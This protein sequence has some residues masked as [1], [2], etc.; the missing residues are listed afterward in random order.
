MTGSIGIDASAKINLHLR[1]L[2]RNADG[3]HGIESL[4]QTV[5]LSDRI[6]VRS[7]KNT[8]ISVEGKFDC[9]PEST[10]VYRAAAA[11]LAAAGI[12]RGVRIEVAKKIPVKAGLG[13]G[14]ADAAAVLKA[15]DLLFGTGLGDARDPQSGDSRLAKIGASIGS[16]VPFFL[17][18]AAAIV[19]GRGDRIRG[20]APRRDLGIVL[21]EPRFGS[22]TAEAYAVLDAARAAGFRPERGFIPTL[23]GPDGMESEYRND[24]A[25]WRFFNDFQDVLGAKNSAYGRMGAALAGSGAAFAALSGSGSSFF[26]IY[27]SPDA[28][29][30]AAGELPSRFRAMGFGESEVPYIH[31]LETL[32]S[33]LALV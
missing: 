22:S 25:S 1:V 13:G 2:G 11:F 31:V 17:G 15:L 32:A 24:P 28:A 29:H 16:D 23:D 33:P 10:T 8:D 3:F 7:L 4:F 30:A 27:G 18:E 14:S 21:V 12:S 6:V 9:R 20:I 5:G 26:G 19:S